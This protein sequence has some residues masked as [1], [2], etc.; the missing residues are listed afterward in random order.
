M[1][2]VL[3]HE[4]ATDHAEIERLL[5][6]AF[7]D[8]RRA[9]T[10][11]RFRDSVAPLTGTGFVARAGQRILGSIRCWPIGMRAI[12]SST[13]A[14]CLLGPLA[15][16][17]HLRGSGIGTALLRRGLAALE[18]AYPDIPVFLIGD[19]PYYSRVGF[20]H[21]L[22][23]Q[24][25]LPGPVDPDRVLVRLPH[26]VDA[27]ALPPSFRLEPLAVSSFHG[28]SRRFVGMRQA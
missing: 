22:P 1:L 13:E 8:G 20:R 3:D 11:Y 19:A 27:D 6:A 9:L 2:F 15:V 18:E 10:S 14:A 25:Q 5:D 12:D 7:G 21:A 28:L 26:G 4:R 24:V 16:A 17:P 23:S